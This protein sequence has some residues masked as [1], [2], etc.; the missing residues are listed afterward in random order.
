MTKKKPRWVTPFLRALERTGVA[1]AAAADAGVD[2]TTA[3][4]RR[5]THADFATDWAWVVQAYAERVEREKAEELE[6]FLSAQ[7]EPSPGSPA[8]SPTSPACGRGEL[9]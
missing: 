8:A 1:R 3:Y 5:R 9:V 6:G 2:Y 4:A 7:G